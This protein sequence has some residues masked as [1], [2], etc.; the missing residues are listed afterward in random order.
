MKLVS[1]V[2]RLWYF[3]FY[4]SIISIWFIQEIL[5]Y[6]FG[7]RLFYTDLYYVIET[8]EGILF[9]LSLFG[10][11]LIYKELDLKK[12][13]IDIASHIILDLKNENQKLNHIQKDFINLV[14]A[15]FQSWNLSKSEAEIGIMIL[16]GLTNQ[17]IAGIRKKSLKTIENQMFSI[18]QKSGTTGKLEFIAYFLFPL[19]P[20]EE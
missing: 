12:N 9:L 17:Q 20:E 10:L 5:S 6:S 7:N 16:R 2:K 13:Q 1:D 8:V 14:N 11:Y 4:F 3:V 19:L 15:Q 18:Y